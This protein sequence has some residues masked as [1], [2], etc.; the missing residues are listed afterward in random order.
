LAIAYS[1]TQYV[2]PVGSAGVDVMDM[3]QVRCFVT[4]AE[5]SHFGR[6]A[7]RLHLTPSPVSRAVKELERELGADL[8]IR[9]YH[10]VEL[11]P[12]GRAVLTRA[13]GLLAG[14]AELKAVAR[15]AA[16]PPCVIHV[17]GTYLAPPAWFDR[18]VDIAEEVADG[19][20]V[21]ISVAPSAELLPDVESGTLEFALVHLPVDETHLE[22]LTIARYRYLVAMRSDDPLTSAGELRLAD[23]TDR[24]ITMTSHRSRT[25]ALNA[26]HEYLANSGIT[27]I[28]SL[29]EKDVSLLAS[30][31]RSSRG[32]ALT[33]PPEVGGRSRVFDDPAF[34]L[35]PLHDG[36]YYSVGV[37][38]RRDRAGTGDVAALAAAARRAWGDG[39]KII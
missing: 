2:D 38:W 11:T 23:L 33:L 22:S 10:Q 30:R 27:K 9:R 32:L 7:E 39:P 5:E 36:L 29:P 24:T 14:F 15:G 4:V 37:T 18:M 8:F 31:I 21:D 13:R 6:A 3:H 28:H 34:A 19:R 20:P 1:K 17:G 35:V 26:F 25:T 12:A 16:T